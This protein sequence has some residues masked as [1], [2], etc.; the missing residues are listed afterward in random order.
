MAHD[1][2]PEYLL[3]A[4]PW[5]LTSLGR[6]A[7]DL[8]IILLSWVMKSKMRRALGFAPEARES[9]DTQALLTCADK[10]E[11]S[12]ENSDWV[13]LTTLPPC[14]SLRT[15]AAISRYLE[16]TIEPVQQASCSTTRLPGDG[17]MSPGDATLQEPP[18]Y[19]PV[20]VIRARV[21]SSS[22]C[23]VSSINSDLE[24]KYWE[25]LNSEQWD[26]EDVNLEGNKD[27]VEMLRSQA[28]RSS[29]GPVALTSEEEHLEPAHQPRA[30]SQ[31]FVRN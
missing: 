31:A 16:L 18:S 12:Q 22:S 8:S 5:F 30:P 19:P 21:S 27:N 24:Q 7:L 26:P 13:P 15:M 6:A 2:R 28:H 14:K 3:R 29:L 9:P 20:Q 17:Q 1:R 11:E 4:T 23:E 25:A 10:E